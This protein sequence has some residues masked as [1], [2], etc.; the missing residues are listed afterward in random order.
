MSDSRRALRPIFS[1][2]LITATALGLMNVFSDNADV[3]A[4]AHDTACGGKTCNA[5]LTQMSRNPFTQGFTF[6]TNSNTSSAIHV[7]CH[8][9]YYLIGP[10]E[11][12]RSAE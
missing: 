6:Q 7:S 11:C 12:S 1:I 8:R 9:T 5:Q 4:Q 10:Y 3:K 2:L